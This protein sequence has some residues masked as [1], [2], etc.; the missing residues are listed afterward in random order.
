MYVVKV[1][2]IRLTSTPRSLAMGFNAGKYMFC[3]EQNTQD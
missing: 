2:L 1:R 3:G